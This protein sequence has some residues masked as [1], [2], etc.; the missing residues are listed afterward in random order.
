MLKLKKIAGM[1]FLTAA[2]A[3]APAVVNAQQL[4]APQQQQSRT[5]TPYTAGNGD[6]GARRHAFPPSKAKR[7]NASTRQFQGGGVSAV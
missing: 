3:A 4:P 1:M 2:L 7:D 6:G 5:R